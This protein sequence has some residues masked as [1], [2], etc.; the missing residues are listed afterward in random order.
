[1]RTGKKEECPQARLTVGRRGWQWQITAVYTTS[2]KVAKSMIC[3]P[4]GS[5]QEQSM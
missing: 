1:M 3:D 4:R 5:G 2:V